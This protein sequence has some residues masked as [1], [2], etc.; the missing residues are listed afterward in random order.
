MT[1][2]RLVFHRQVFAL[3]ECALP[4][5]TLATIASW[6]SIFAFR[7]PIYGWDDTIFYRQSLVEAFHSGGFLGLF[8]RVFLEDQYRTMEILK[9]FL[10]EWNPLANQCLLTVFFLLFHFVSGYFVLLRWPFAAA[11]ERMKDSLILIT[12]FLLFSS[13]NRFFIFNSVWA[14]GGMN[15]LGA[16][17]FFLLVLVPVYRLLIG[18][19]V[20]NDTFW[21]VSTAF[22][23]G[24]FVNLN[25][26]STVPTVLVLSFAA[27]ALAWWRSKRIQWWCAA[28]FLS[29]LAA[30]AIMVASD[31]RLKHDDYSKVEL[32]AFLLAT[33]STIPEG[34]WT[35]ISK[36]LGLAIFAP[37]IFLSGAILLRS[38]H[39]RTTFPGLNSA[40]LILGIFFL[41]LFFN[42]LVLG[43][44]RYGRWNLWAS[45]WFG[46]A[47][48]A[49]LCVYLRFIQS[50]MLRLISII[51][52]GALLLMGF[53][54]QATLD[55]E[56]LAALSNWGKSRDSMIAGLLVNQS[57]HVELSAEDFYEL[58][59][60][61]PSSPLF[62]DHHIPLDDGSKEILPTVKQ[63]YGLNNMSFTRE[64]AQD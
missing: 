38:P 22:I 15:H 36:D 63:F 58:R 50:S 62:T 44:M 64:P 52:I 16:T 49:S 57:N 48:T 20:P 37:I 59:F 61:M 41:A 1:I 56:K 43:A 13:F 6:F 31:F 24:L 19:S 46:I 34:A 27:I 21:S 18:L 60:L 26:E 7:M 8:R 14:S 4:I 3:G 2:S 35:F 45:T 42:Q 51:A 29:G 12:L 47:F 33:A 55:L 32:L 10:M 11:G 39:P 23:V 5:L 40:L 30:I 9:R 53:I 25:I 17:V 54:P 28:F